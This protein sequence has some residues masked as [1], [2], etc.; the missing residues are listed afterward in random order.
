MLLDT[1]LNTDQFMPHGMCYLWRPD[2]LWTSVISDV[3]IAL[4][5]YS[6]TVAFI[7]FVKKRKDLKYPWFFI[8]DGS[9]IFVACGTSHLIGAVVVWEPI[10][11]V[12]AIAKAVTA[13][14]SLA[15]GIANW[16]VLPFFVS[17]PSP[18]MLEKKVAERT[19]DLKSSNEALNK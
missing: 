3:V 8:L 19:L 2:V 14:S 7:V 16:Y 13:V 11:G 12:S 10:Y 9:I 4:A 18:A 5:Y 6:I 15:T 17:I 1:F